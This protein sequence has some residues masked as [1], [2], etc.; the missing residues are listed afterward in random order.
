MI[1]H[2]NLSSFSITR[3]QK[4]QEVMA[5]IFLMCSRVGAS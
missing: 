2:L 5:V 1:S 4:A 3:K